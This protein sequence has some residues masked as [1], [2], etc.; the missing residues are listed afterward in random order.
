MTVVYCVVSQ[1]D[2]NLFEFGPFSL[3]YSG[4]DAV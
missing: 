1:R 4:K 2:S 3:F